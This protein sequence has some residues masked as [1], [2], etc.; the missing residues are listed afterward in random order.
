MNPKTNKK[1]SNVTT[2]AIRATVILVGIFILISFFVQWVSGSISHV[3]SRAN[4]NLRFPW[5]GHLQFDFLSSST[6]F[7]FLAY[8]VYRVSSWCRHQARLCGTLWNCVYWR[9]RSAVTCS[10]VPRVI[11]SP[12]VITT[13]IAGCASMDFPLLLIEI[14]IARAG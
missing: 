9:F 3:L 6:K 12:S 1:S 10:H 4:I 5:K 8:G 7:E 11:Y 14:A 2:K 13:A